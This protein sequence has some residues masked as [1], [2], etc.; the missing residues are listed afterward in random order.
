MLGII[1][2]YTSPEN[3]KYIGQTTDKDRLSKHLYLCKKGLDIP[4]YNAIRKYGVENFK[5]EILY[6]KEC[7]NKEKLEEILNSKEKYYIKRFNLTGKK[8]PTS[9]SGAMN[10]L[11]FF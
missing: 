7:D 11:I 2:C 6:S 1:Y 4:F 10:C 9:I 3:K 5:F 8:S